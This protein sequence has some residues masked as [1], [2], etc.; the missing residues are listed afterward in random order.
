MNGQRRYEC[1]VVGR[2]QSYLV[3]KKSFWNWHHNVLGF[4]QQTVGIHMCNNSASLPDVGIEAILYI[5]Q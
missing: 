3:N 5:S 4:C 1:P 2:E